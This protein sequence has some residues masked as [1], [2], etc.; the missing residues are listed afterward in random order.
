MICHHF[1]QA[2]ARVRRTSEV[3][4]GAEDQVTSAQAPIFVDDELLVLDK[5]AGMLTVPGRGEDKADCLWSRA[6]RQ[7]PGARVVHRLDMATSGLVLFA[8][9]AAMQR[10]LSMAFARREV[11]K[12]YEAIVTGLIDG[13]EGNIELPLAADWPN[14]P[15]QQVDAQHG[16]AS[17]TS[18]RVLARDE[19]AQRTHVELTPHTGRTH[20]LRVHLAA[21]GHAIVGDALYASPDVV[22]ASPRLLLHATALGLQHPQSREAL[23]WHSAAPFALGASAAITMART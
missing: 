17:L 13:D 8:R 19:K 23:N 18:W 15:R 5:P 6:L 1:E 21:I 11:L 10:R 20:Q 9:G 7:W 3:D 14:R 2:A 12:N 16:K 22:A 4:C